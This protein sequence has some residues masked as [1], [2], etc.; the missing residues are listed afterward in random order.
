MVPMSTNC[1]GTKIGRFLGG[2]MCSLI[3]EHLGRYT[4]VLP[5]GGPSWKKGWS[6]G[7]FGSIGELLLVLLHAATYL[8][9]HTL[10]HLCRIRD[11][12]VVD[13]I[14]AT[15]SLAGTI[16][17]WTSN[18]LISDLGNETNLSAAA[19][20]IKLMQKTGF[21]F[22]S[23]RNHCL[24]PS[25]HDMDDLTG[26]RSHCPSKLLR[27]ILRCGE[28]QLANDLIASG[29][30][31]V[32]HDVSTDSA[33]SDVGPCTAEGTSDSNSDPEI[34]KNVQFV[35]AVRQEIVQDVRSMLPSINDRDCLD[36]AFQTAIESKNDELVDMLLG[37]EIPPRSGFLCAVR[38]C[39]TRAAKKFF[40]RHVISPRISGFLDG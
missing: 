39:N 17:D 15:P 40:D 20:T 16:R 28:I 22:Q 30:T 12:V 38:S 14:L 31:C 2:P 21:H 3:T 24:R 19:T 13:W 34:D 18:K 32:G 6:L 35:S 9:K 5:E 10:N 7:W 25:E 4:V 36:R 26:L 27:N 8:H 33:I 29:F 1:T 37:A 11:T 23:Y